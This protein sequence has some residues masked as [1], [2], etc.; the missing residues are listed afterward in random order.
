M[1]KEQALSKLSG[2]WLTYEFKHILEVYTFTDEHLTEEARGEY[3]GYKQALIDAK[4]VTYDDTRLIEN[5]R[6]TLKEV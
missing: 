2:L 5:Q 6:L 1:D 3:Y 4:L